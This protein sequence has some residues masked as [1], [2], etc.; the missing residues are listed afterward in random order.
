[1][2]KGRGCVKGEN[3]FSGFTSLVFG[4]R[5]WGGVASILRRTSSGLGAVPSLRGSSFIGKP[6]ENQTIQA[7]AQILLTKVNDL[8]YASLDTGEYGMPYADE[9]ILKT[10]LRKLVELDLATHQ[11]IEKVLQFLPQ[12][13][14][15]LE[16]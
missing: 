13:P 9:T 3:Y 12:H 5:G 1:M 15:C 4:L 14:E 8:Y 7:K 2:G 11:K 6:S 10:I 16:E